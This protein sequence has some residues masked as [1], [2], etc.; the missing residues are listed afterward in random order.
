LCS[1]TINKNF[2]K[3]EKKPFEVKTSLPFGVDDQGN[4]TWIGGSEDNPWIVTTSTEIITDAKLVGGKS[5]KQA[6][7]FRNINAV[8]V[9]MPQDICDKIEQAKELGVKVENQFAV[10]IFAY[11]AF[12]APHMS[13]LQVILDRDNLDPQKP[14]TF[15]VAEQ[16][17]QEI[18]NSTDFSTEMIEAITIAFQWLDYL[19]PDA[20]RA[21]RSTAPSED[22]ASF[23]GSGKYTT[24]L[25]VKGADDVIKKIKSCFVSRFNTAALSYQFDAPEAFGEDLAS[26]TFA[27]MVQDMS[28]II[29][30]GTMFSACTQSGHTGFIEINSNYGLGESVV[31]GKV[32]SDSWIFNKRTLSEGFDG[33]VEFKLGEKQEYYWAGK[34]HTTDPERRSSQSISNRN[35]VRITKIGILLSDVFRFLDKDSLQS[36]F[37]WALTGNKEIIITQQRAITT[38]S[39]KQDPVY[40]T[41]EL[42]GLKDGEESQELKS[43]LIM[44]NGINAGVLKIVRGVVIKLLGEG[45]EFVKNFG[46]EFGKELVR[47]KSKFGEDTPVILVTHMTYPWMER[48]MALCKACVTTRGGQNDHTPIWCKEHG[49]PAAVSVK[50]ADKLPT[51][52]WITYYGCDSVPYFY[53]ERVEYSVS[54]LPLVGLK[55]SPIPI[56]LI[57]SNPETARITCEKN[58]SSFVEYWYGIW[59]SSMGNDCNST[60]C[61]SCSCFKI[62]QY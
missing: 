39:K 48:Y 53:N 42:K 60:Q 3:M 58:I 28:K 24:F 20:M 57:L 11:E 9:E 22:G 2:N 52:T 35:A 26:L 51:D 17:C 30:A 16:A 8:G 59:T 27:V 50:K 36:D 46:N 47:I 38:L 33:L 31:S 12:I 32:S 61:T 4:L 13:K 10:T 15:D 14:E 25:E 18:M 6:R 43:R 5:A 44:K 23:S 45:E 21:V 1:L 55:P 49:L 29:S 41:Y 37:E 19:N 7:L 34:Y 54:R 40:E 56:R 62:R